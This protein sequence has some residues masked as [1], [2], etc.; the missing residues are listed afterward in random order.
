MM[1][2]NEI[3]SVCLF[4]L[5]HIKYKIRWG[6]YDIFVHEY[7]GLWSNSPMYHPILIPLSNIIL[8]TPFLLHTLIYVPGSM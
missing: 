1:K 5:V 8:L 4:K 7:H 2:T 3:I 6:S